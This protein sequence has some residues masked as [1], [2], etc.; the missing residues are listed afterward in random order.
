MEFIETRVSISGVE[1]LDKPQEAC[2]V[3]AI[4]AE[5]TDLNVG[6]IVHAGLSE[7]QHRGEDGAGIVLNYEGRMVG[8]D[9]PGLVS[10]LDLTPQGETIIDGSHPLANISIGHVRYS[11]VEQGAEQP[12]VNDSFS[13]AHNGH[14]AN[15]DAV[16]EE[17]GLTDKFTSDSDC[18]AKVIDLFLAEGHSLDDAIALTLPKLEGGYSLVL[19]DGEVLYGIRDPNG[20][21]PLVLGRMNSDNA[22]LFSSEDSAL[23]APDVDAR[24]EREIRPGEIVKVQ[25]GEVTTTLIN[26]EIDE[27][28]CAFEYI[29]FARNDTN[30]NNRNVQITRNAMGEQLA[31]EAPVDAD[32]VIGVKDAGTDAAYGYSH[33]TGIPRPEALGKNRYSSRSFIQKDQAAREKMV[34]TKH[35]PNEAIIRG[36][37]VVLV[38]D[39]I[40]RGTTMRTL[41]QMIREAGA[42]EVHL[43]IPSPIYNWSCHYGMATGDPSTLLARQFPSIEEMREYLGADSLAFL[44]VEG[45]EKSIAIGTG[46]LCLACMDGNYPTPI[47]GLPERELVSQ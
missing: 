45:L 35:R 23:R 34:R 16:A 44:S 5:T 4:A 22:W 38:D 31:R 28:L 43:R 41:V 25:N 6:T 20:F 13:L 27:K 2:G 42:T 7:L 12:I 18:I 46:K 33:E 47:P 9:A 10:N 36:N 29:Y 39:S 26:K 17:F 14:I 24:L 11:T 19:T 1:M 40:V 30:I 32:I 21:R 37:R 8:Q 15:I 3:F